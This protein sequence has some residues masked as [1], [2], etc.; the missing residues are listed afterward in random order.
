MTQ[1]QKDSIR[2]AVF[3]QSFFDHMASEHDVLLL[4]TEKHEIVDVLI[5]QIE[6]KILVNE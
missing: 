4:Q 6:N 1:E 5:K 2:E 3:S